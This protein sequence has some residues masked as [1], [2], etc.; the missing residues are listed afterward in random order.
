MNIA[1]T[2][3]G[4]AQNVT[5]SCYLLEANGSRFLID[6]GLYQERPYLTR[7][8]DS[9]Y[10]PPETLDGVLLTH[11]HLDHC[12]LLPKLVR[13]GFK[14]K[15]YCTQATS[16]I[17]KIVLLDA[18]KIQEED[19]AFKIRRH[20]REG[21]TGPRP[22]KPL[23]TIADAEAT[24]PFF[25]PVA[26]KNPI[27]IADG[28]EACFYEAGHI[29][30]S[31]NVIFRVQQ[32]GESRTILFSGDIGRWETP[33]LLDPTIFNEADYVIMES[34]YGDRLHGNRDHIADQLEEIILSTY[35]AGGNLLIPSFAVERAQEVLYYLNQLLIRD[36]IPHLA[37]FMDSP[38]AI[39]VTQVF[40]MHPEL[41]DNDMLRLLHRNES[42]FAFKGL[43][44]IETIDESKAINHIRGT[45]IIIA[46]SGMCT[47]GR[48]KH[49]LTKNI[50]RYESTVLFVGYQ[51]MGTLG[52]Q[53]VDGNEEVR[54]L[55]QFYRVR[56]RIAQITGFSAHADRDELLRWLAG[57]QNAPR[58]LFVTHGEPEVAQQF[59]DLIRQQKGWNVSV[60]EYQT[61]VVLT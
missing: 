26:Y 16:E 43:K 42:P 59:A 1:I 23:Y 22:V 38:M 39:R 18:A 53:I 17:A 14:G 31:S 37:V 13:E 45:V 49:H 19:A 9:F 28:I 10:V 7:N 24:L 60:P 36:R 5:G 54:I 47:A 58:Q 30:G 51:A 41:F 35:K 55:G 21:R 6:C 52:R 27:T 8:W 57:F 3:L 33:I 56:A 25:Q 48:I 50:E 20:Q 29:L 12:G 4:A 32:D 34:T 11:A 2:F 15:I 44:M 61:R 46:G 40:Q